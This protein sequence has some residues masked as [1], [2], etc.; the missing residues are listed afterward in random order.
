MPVGGPCTRLPWA[1][2]VRHALE[3]RIVLLTATG[4]IALVALSQPAA[5]AEPSPVGPYLSGTRIDSPVDWSQS[6]YAAQP[7]GG[8]CADCGGSH[9]GHEPCHLWRPGDLLRHTQQAL[10]PPPGFRHSSTHGRSIGCGHPM[11]GTSWLNRP[12]HVGWFAG[13]MW[14]SPMIQGHVNQRGTFFGGYQVG[15]DFDHYWGKQLRFAWASPSLTPG[16][17]QR[18][19]IPLRR[20]RRLLS[21]GRFA[22]PALFI[23]GSWLWAI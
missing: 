23:G 2:S 9:A 12:Y 18:T 21:V 6:G 1:T 20:R 8:G 7:D 14:G 22:D 3:S 16:Y 11:G 13:A 10:C 19:D 4:I 15:H 17:A 5:S